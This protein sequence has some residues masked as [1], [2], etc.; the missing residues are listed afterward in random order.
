LLIQSFV[1]DFR[2]SF[3]ITLMLF[4]TLSAVLSTSASRAEFEFWS[5]SRIARELPPLIEAAYV[6]TDDDELRL[7]PPPGMLRWMLSPPG[8][9][10]ELQVGI[11]VRGEAQLI[12]FVAAVPSALRL[13]GERHQAAVE[14][15]LLC[16]RRQWRGQGLTRVLL[17]ELRR[18]CDAAGVQ[19]AVY[20]ASR[21]RRVRPLLRAACF[22]RPLL[23]KALLESA[24][25]RAE[26]T[27]NA[28]DPN[29]SAAAK[30]QTRIT[31]ADVR[32]A[33]YEAARLPQPLRRTPSSPRLRRMRAD[34]ALE[35]LALSDEHARA[36]ALAHSFSMAQFRHRFLGCGAISLVLRGRPRHSR[37]RCLFWRR[38][39]H[40]EGSGGG[41]G[42]GGGD[43]GSG[44]ADGGGGT[45]AGGGGPLLGFISFT[46]LPLRS[47][48][49][50][51]L[52]QAQ[53]L[54]LALMPGA[55]TEETLE[56]LVDGALRTARREGAA[57]FNALAVGDLSPARLAALGFVQG[58]GET[59]VHVEH[60]SAVDAADEPQT[61]DPS[62][63]SWTP[64][65]S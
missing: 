31:A 40:L 26:A 49:G 57:V 36:F 6:A 22:H 52:V 15:S 55:P 38:R 45:G 11:G 46:L 34:D 23:A 53:L 21:P 48:S 64:M 2:K 3:V 59:F 44:G 42:S 56:R 33:L 62:A 51:R 47:A 4:L 32:K 24:F 18:R 25:L 19:L 10:D 28:A 16:L 50:K 65:L 17:E 43:A 61:I 30:E 12:G 13:R 60:S 9:R 63:V 54:G 39:S 27:D 37:H 7:D 1:A 58:D 41:H 20:T 5:A 8:M 14:V 35:C 29:E